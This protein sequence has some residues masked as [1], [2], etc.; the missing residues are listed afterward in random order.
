[1]VTYVLKSGDSHAQQWLEEAVAFVNAYD[2]VAM[3]IT[4]VRM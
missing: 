4:T 3:T 1:V 2:N